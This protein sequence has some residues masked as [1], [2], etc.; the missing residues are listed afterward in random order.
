ME[1]DFSQ[2]S[3]WSDTHTHTY[4]PTFA[5]THTH[6][7]AATGPLATQNSPL[8]LG[9]DEA[10]EHDN[11]LGWGGRAGFCSRQ[12]VEMCFEVSAFDDAKCW[13]IHKMGL[14]RC[15]REK[16]IFYCFPTFSFVFRTHT[17]TAS[18]RREYRQFL[19]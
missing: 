18:A 8:G 4:I 12:N 3:A 10:W 6:I 13:N 7:P 17:I 11:S 1:A 15:V 5:H 9:G 16:H 19:Q 2:T 14:C